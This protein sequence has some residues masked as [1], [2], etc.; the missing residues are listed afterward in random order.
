MLAPPRLERSDD[1]PILNG[2]FLVVPE[3]PRSGPDLRRSPW[4]ERMLAIAAKAELDVGPA[5]FP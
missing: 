5:K 2:R 3:E 4:L 1:A